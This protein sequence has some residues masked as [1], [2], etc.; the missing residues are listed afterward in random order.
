MELFDGSKYEVYLEPTEF[1][2]ISCA[3]VITDENHYFDDRR[4]IQ[5][6]KAEGDICWPCYEW[7]LEG[8]STAHVVRDG[9]VTTYKVTDYFA[10]DQWGEEPW[11][12]DDVFFSRGWV[13]TDGWRG[14]GYTKVEDWEEVP[15]LSG[16]TT[17]GWGDATSN[18]KQTFNEWASG[19]VSGKLRYPCR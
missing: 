4:Y 16:W 9:E 17:G 2:C 10:M 18:R 14:Y 3:E 7:S 12:T 13:S 19:V 5:S 11:A 1:T 15:G 6:D 8:A